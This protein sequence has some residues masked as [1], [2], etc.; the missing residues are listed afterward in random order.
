MHGTYIC[1]V[2]LLGSLF[3]GVPCSPLQYIHYTFIVVVVQ[4]DEGRSPVE[5]VVVLRNTSTM[6]KGKGEVNTRDQH[7]PE[8]QEGVYVCHP[9]GVMSNGI[10][11]YVTVWLRH[12]LCNYDYIM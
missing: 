6:V 10:G 11:S 12:S 8:R 3:Y 1:F 7:N 2:N 9:G 4:V 5:L